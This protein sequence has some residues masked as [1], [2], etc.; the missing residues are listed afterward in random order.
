MCIFIDQH[1]ER[2]PYLASSK[3]LTEV[4]NVDGLTLVCD[5][6]LFE[7]TEDGFNTKLKAVR[8]VL[9]KYC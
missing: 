2:V 3:E 6:V 9:W 7:R 1:C 4:S 5:V 8:Q